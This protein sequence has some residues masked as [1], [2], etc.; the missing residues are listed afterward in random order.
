MRCAAAGVVID[1]RLNKSVSG[2]TRPAR[3][4]ATWDTAGEALG[5]R[6]VVHKL[7][8]AYAPA[9]KLIMKPS[10]QNEYRI[11]TISVELTVGAVE[12]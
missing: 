1:Q 12:L 8:L 4:Y 3:F 11:E 6:S 2:E 10:P 7:K 9:L 5:G